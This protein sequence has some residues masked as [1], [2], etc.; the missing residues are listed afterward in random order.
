MVLGFG[1]RG[2][3]PNVVNRYRVRAALRSLRSRN[4]RLVCSGGSVHGTISEAELLAGHAR[5][6]GYRG[7]LVTESGSRLT[8]ENITN[9]L[10]Y[11]ED[12]GRI[13]IVSNSLHAEKARAYLWHLRPDL[14]ER[15]VKA[16]DYRFGELILLKPIMAALGAWS[17]RRLP[18]TL[19]EAKPPTRRSTVPR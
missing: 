2:T 11:L 4:P 5:Q 1:N 18:V 19:A 14:A 15:L 16:D 12:A 6:L 10:P 13:R 8:W 7:E 3:K 17:L 9:V